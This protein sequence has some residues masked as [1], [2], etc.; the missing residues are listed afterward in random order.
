VNFYLNAVDDLLRHPDDQP[1]IGLVLCREKEGSNKMLLEY[2]L[3]GLEKPVGVSAYQL[4]RALPDNLKPS[5][6]TVEEIEI[7]IAEKVEEDNDAE[8]GMIIRE[9]AEKYRTRTGR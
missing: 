1:S 3:R 4:T 5:L 7:E 8:T 6:P 2:A 9:W